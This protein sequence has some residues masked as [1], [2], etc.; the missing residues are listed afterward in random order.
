MRYDSEEETLLLLLCLV[1]LK[2]KRKGTWKLCIVK[3]PVVKI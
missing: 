2:I 3:L 1:S